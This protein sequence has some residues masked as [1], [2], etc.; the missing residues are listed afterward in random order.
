MVGVE[1]GNY[2][3]NSFEIGLL[4]NVACHTGCLIKAGM[5]NMMIMIN[6]GI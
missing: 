5:T 3:L 2:G 1:M 6:S 4:S